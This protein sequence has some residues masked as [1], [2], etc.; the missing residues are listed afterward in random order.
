MRWPRNVYTTEDTHRYV[1]KYL[2]Q[3][4]L[5]QSSTGTYI[6]LKSHTHADIGDISL[7]FYRSIMM[8]FITVIL[9]KFLV[10]PMTAQAVHRMVSCKRTCHQYHGTHVL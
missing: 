2:T 4:K 7:S 10:N 1:H 5:T 8:V 6:H 3:T 9:G